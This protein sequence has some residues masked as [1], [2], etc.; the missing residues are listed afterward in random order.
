MAHRDPHCL[1][2]TLQRTGSGAK[3][4]AGS[5]GGALWSCLS[6]P[7]DRP[8]VPHDRIS[9]VSDHLIRV[10]DHLDG[11]CALP[12]AGGGCSADLAQAV[13]GRGNRQRPGLGRPDA[14]IAHLPEVGRELPELRRDGVGVLIERPDR[15]RRNVSACRRGRSSSSGGLQSVPVASRLPAPDPAVLAAGISAAADLDAPEQTPDAGKARRSEGSSPPRPAPDERP[16]PAILPAGGSAADPAMCDR[17]PPISPS[18]PSS[19][20]IRSRARSRAWS[21]PGRPEPCRSGSCSARRREP[22]F[23]GSLSL[24]LAN[25]I[26]GTSMAAAPCQCRRKPRWPG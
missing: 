18:S 19:A 20:S 13:P 25:R 12:A 1:Q 11:E 3:A 6:L 26:T 17:L 23:G 16:I 2:G 5:R 7:A 8:A 10:V 22:G 24:S 14:R 9:V 21:D 4:P 15:A